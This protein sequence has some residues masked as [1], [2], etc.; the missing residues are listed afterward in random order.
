[1]T[2]KAK[3]KFLADNSEITCFFNPTEYTIARPITWT[4]N[5]QT[6]YDVPAFTFG[7]IGATTMTLTLLFDT[8]LTGNTDV[9]TTYTDKLWKAAR[10]KN[11]GEQAKA[12]S[13]ILFSWGTNWSFE[14]VV[15]NL[16]QK[17]TLFKE[18]GTPVRTEVTLAMT[19]VKD[20]G[21]FAGQNPTSGGGT[22]EMHIVNEGDRLDLIAAKYYKKPTLWREI[23]EHN[24][25]NN[26]RSLTPGQ[27]LLIPT[28]S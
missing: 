15:T 27:R 26:P 17:F 13:N 14:A 8:T 9:R 20:P 6:H 10:V 16:S 21:T 18:D 3:I 25:I 28:L 24:G 2:T 12:P 4:P 7:G 11:P 22:G 5:H 1:M 19:Q 23:A